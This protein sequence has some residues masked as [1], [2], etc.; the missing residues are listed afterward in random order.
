MPIDPDVDAARNDLIQDM[1]YSQC[2]TKLG[3]VKG[4]GRVM[5]S[6]PRATPSGTIYHTDG[7]RAVFLFEQKSVS[8]SEIEFF[9]WE[10]LIDHHRQQ[11]G[12][13]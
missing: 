13:Q 1:V 10:R 2:L 11:Y 12:E 8:L 7:L 5:A 4:V 6:Q 9:D 3:F